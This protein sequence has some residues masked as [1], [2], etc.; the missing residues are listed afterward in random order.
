MTEPM[1]GPTTRPPAWLGLYERLDAG[2]NRALLTAR[3]AFDGAWLGLLDEHRLAALDQRH[4]DAQGEYVDDDYNR[5][6]LQGWERRLVDA[7]F[8][9]GARV[10]VTGAGG[11]R[12]VLA[13]LRLGYDAVGFEPHPALAAAGDRLLT[14]HGHPGRLRRSGRRGWPGGHERFD[15][16][17][18]GWGAY[19]LV[20]SRRARVELL[21]EASGATGGA[22]PVAV[23]YFE[24]AQPLHRFRAAQRVAAPLRRLRRAEPVVLGDALSPNFVHYFSPRQVEHEFAAAGLALLERGSDGYG[25]AVGR[26][27]GVEGVGHDR[28]GR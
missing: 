2:L 20:P 6:G 16:V 19:M 28:A 27:G 21:A 11:G 25:W 8:A 26:R 24:M 10:A 5:G 3:G 15:A 12:E 9:P 14:D 17:L 18:V 1:S 23:S 4:Y 7:H 22:G 13:L